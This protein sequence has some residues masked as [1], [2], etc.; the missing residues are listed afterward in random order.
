MHTTGG[1]SLRFAKGMNTVGPADTGSSQYGTMIVSRLAGYR[2][3]GQVLSGTGG[4]VPG[5]KKE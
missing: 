4:T 2:L 1:T 3:P 5:M